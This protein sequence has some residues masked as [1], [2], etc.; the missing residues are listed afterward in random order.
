MWYSRPVVLVHPVDAADHG[1]GP[2][3]HPAQPAV[4]EPVADAEDAVLLRQVAHLARGRRAAAPWRPRCAAATARG[5]GGCAC[6]RGPP[7]RAGCAPRDRGSGSPPRR[8][9]PPSRPRPP[10]R[11]SPR[12]RGS[13]T[14]GCAMSWTQERVAGGAGE[15]QLDLVGGELSAAEQRPRLVG[16]QRGEVQR[17]DE[18]E[19]ERRGGEVGPL[20]DAGEALGGGEDRPHLRP[21]LEDAAQAGEDEGVRPRHGQELLRLVH[22]QEQPPPAAHGAADQ[23]GEHVRHRQPLEVL[24][25]DVGRA[26]E[27]LAVLDAAR[28]G[29]RPGRGRPRCPAGPSTGGRTASAALPCTR[30]SSSFSRLVFPRRRAPTTQSESRAPSRMSRRMSARPKKLS[31]RT[32][33]PAMNGLRIRS[34]LTPRRGLRPRCG[35]RRGPRSARPRGPLRRPRR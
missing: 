16:G 25:P 18:P 11:G 4:E 5:P 21:L 14:G 24:D 15:D 23:G 28:A 2:R 22:E 34:R 6:R 17:G 9:W 13:R 10:G 32:Q 30:R 31:P 33:L 26:A 8:S 19:E 29:C 27:G 1:P 35:R 3:H 12:G 20:V 7:P